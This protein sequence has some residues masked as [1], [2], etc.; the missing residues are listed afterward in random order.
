[1][2]SWLRGHLVH[3]LHSS[4]LPV[5]LS[6]GNGLFA[7]LRGHHWVSTFLITVVVWKFNETYFSVYCNEIDLLFTVIFNVIEYI[8]YLSLFVC[9]DQP[10]RQGR[11][12]QHHFRGDVWADKRV[13]SPGSDDRGLQHGSTV[14]RLLQ[15]RQPRQDWVQREFSA[16]LVTQD[17]FHIIIRNY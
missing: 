4:G 7:S 12:H 13:H 11:Q 15:H 6:G 8:N 17:I 14:C 1:M 5:R 2:P 16:A 9:A 10:S 3:P